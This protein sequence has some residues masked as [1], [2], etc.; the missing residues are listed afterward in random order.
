MEVELAAVVSKYDRDMAAKTTQIEEIKVRHAKNR[1][2]PFCCTP[3]AA[4]W[5]LGGMRGLVVL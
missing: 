1:F 5:S 3:G 4:C 2:A